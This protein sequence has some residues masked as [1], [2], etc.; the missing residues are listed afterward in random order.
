MF[1]S[2]QHRTMPRC[3]VLSGNRRDKHKIGSFVSFIC[4]LRPYYC[5]GVRPNQ[6]FFDRHENILDMQTILASLVLLLE[7]L[8]LPGHCP[9][10]MN[11]TISSDVLASA[12]SSGISADPSRT[13]LYLDS[14]PHGT[15]ILG[16]VLLSTR[17]QYRL[18][19]GFIDVC[20]AVRILFHS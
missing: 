4:G 19:V 10:S 9:L 6:S 3:S 18:F 11:Y 17:A 14:P 13:D 15:G 1:R 5:T 2:Q 8:Q 12:L 20:L 16:T 7:S